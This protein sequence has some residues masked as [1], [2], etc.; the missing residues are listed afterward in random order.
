MSAETKPVHIIAPDK[1][2]FLFKEKIVFLLFHHKNVYC[3]YSLKE[4][5]SHSFAIAQKLGILLMGGAY[6]ERWRVKR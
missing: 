5:I 2:I 1:V 4:N 6:G 3:G